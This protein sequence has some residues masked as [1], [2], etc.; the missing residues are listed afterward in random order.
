M[1]NGLKQYLFASAKCFFYYDTHRYLM[2]IR[3][4]PEITVGMGPA[5]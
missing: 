4:P 3:L 5:Y 2:K 1:I